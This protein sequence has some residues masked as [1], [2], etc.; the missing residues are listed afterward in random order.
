MARKKSRPAKPAPVPATA[1]QA[2]RPVAPPRT[3]ITKPALVSRPSAN[4]LEPAKSPAS[5]PVERAWIET[6]GI[7]AMHI[8]GSLQLAVPL[9][10]LFALSVLLGTL[11]ESWYTQKIAQ[12]LVYRS[13]WFVFLL[14]M[15]SLCIFFAAVKKW[16]WKR[17]QTG[18]VITHV[19]LLTMLA[20]GILNGLYGTDATLALV[21]TNDIGLQRSLSKR[22]GPVHQVSE[23]YS[24]N[25]INDVL[26]VNKTLGHDADGR[27]VPK[28]AKRRQEDFEGGPLPWHAGGNLRVG[29]DPWLVIL[30]FLQSPFGRGWYRDLDGGDQLEAINYLPSARHVPFSP[31]AADDKRAFPAFKIT[32]RTSKQP[33][34]LEEWLA[35]N[36]EEQ[37]AEGL[38]VLPQFLGT[39]PE[40]LLPEF[41]NPPAAAE[42]GPKGILVVRM[43]GQ[44]YRLPVEDLVKKGGWAEVAKT[45]VQIKVNEYVPSFQKGDGQEPTF[46]IVEFEWKQGGAEGKYK[47][48]ARHAGVLLDVGQGGIVTQR[49]G[50]PR[51]FWYHPPDLRWGDKNLRGV[52]DLVQVEEGRLYYRE[53]ANHEQDGKAEF[54]RASSGRAE[55]GR[56]YPVFTKMNFR[57]RVSDYLPKAVK[58]DRYVPIDAIPG[59]ENKE[60]KMQATPAIHF[61]LTGTD[62]GGKKDVREFWVGL[63][64]GGETVQ[65]GK[66]QYEIRFTSKT[67]PL[68]FELKLERAEQTV[69]PG[70]RAPATYTSFVEVS[71]P[72][73]G[74][75]G[76]KEE[77]TMNQPL[78]WGGLTFYQSQLERTP[79]NDAFGRPVSMSG[80]TVSHD[81]GI[82]LKYLGS[83]F[84]SLGI[85]CMFYMKAY[86]FKPRHRPALAT[87]SGPVSPDGPTKENA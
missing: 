14:F 12:E 9:L 56:E 26:I 34:P 74:V 11:M 7:R 15:L 63:G 66:R 60:D 24:Y 77:I 61:R 51:L 52:L 67:K 21:D 64:R 54:A 50:D 53:F 45:G 33:F 62:I 82:G 47:I 78:T 37:W 40:T 85:I 84:L 58:R 48:M 86:F 55:L 41:L 70:T 19:G 28:E 83:I 29:R 35:L 13:W 3:D 2:A 59:K 1:V 42:L 76:K 44:N 10:I 57:F 73:H 32:L 79:Y 87:T 30:S 46:P 17:H 36:L 18:F 4:G 5:K 31:A 20:G 65:T 81:P 38:P 22:Y 39:C 72:A 69:D 75:K 8:L 16:P 27:L 80:F 68:G 49:D 6:A 25:D 43:A 71:D 23:H